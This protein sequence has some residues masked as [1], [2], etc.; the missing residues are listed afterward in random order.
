MKFLLKNV[1]YPL[2]MFALCVLS[3]WAFIKDVST[4]LRFYHR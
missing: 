4:Q 1:V 2:F 3:I